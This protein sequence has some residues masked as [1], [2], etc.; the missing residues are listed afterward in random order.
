MS[1]DLTLDEIKKAR[2]ALAAKRDETFPE[3]TAVEVEK[4]ALEE[5]QIVFA[6]EQ[7][8]GKVGKGLA[9]VRLPSGQLVVGR[10]PALATYQKYY[11]AADKATF[12]AMRAFV[13][14][15]LVHPAD[16]TEQGVLIDTYPGAFDVLALALSRLCGP[17]P[18]G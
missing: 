14:P 2:A 11:D 12:L 10:K 7:V 5:E 4:Q 18:K 13:L 16:K 17:D 15:C 3:P 9:L 6:L 1:D 8:H